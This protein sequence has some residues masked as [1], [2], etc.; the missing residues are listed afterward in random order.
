MKLVSVLL[1][2]V[3]ACSSDRDDDVCKPDDADGIASV[4][5]TVALTID[6]TS[7]QP[8]IV[9]TQ[10]MSHVKLT[11]TNAGTKPHGFSV[12][13]L[14]TPNSDGCPT[15]SCFPV[16]AKIDPIAPGQ[17]AKVEFTTPAVEG[18]YTFRSDEATG[19]FIL[20]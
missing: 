18:I 19:Q 2:L 6:D 11:L 15:S 12:D 20:Q 13:C 5:I 8:S 9:K 17:S 10:N 3:L 4:D 16:E 7:F 14:P 1:S